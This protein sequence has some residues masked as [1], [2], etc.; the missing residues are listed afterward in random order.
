MS[1]PHYLASVHHDGSTRYVSNPYPSFGETV[2]LRVRAGLD[3]PVT[4]VLVRTAPDGEQ[5]FAELQRADTD[6]VCTWWET[7]LAASM[8]V[9]GYHFVL[10]TPDGLWHYNAAG[11]HAHTPT[12]YADFR[13]LADYAAPRWVRRS[14]FYQIFPD[15]FA[16][17]DPAN[18]VRGGEWTYR[19][20]PTVARGW[21]ERPNQ[22]NPSLEFYGGDL[23]GITQRLPY[24]E[25]LGVDA[26]Y[27]NPIFTAPSVHRYDVVDYDNVDPHLGGNDALVELRRATGERGM[28]L[29][30]DLVP[31]HC[32]VE[33]PW[34]RAAQADPRSPTAEFFTW[35]QHPHEYLSW[36]GVRTLPKLN[37]RSAELRERM[38][39]ASDSVFRRWLRPPFSIDAWRV[40]VANMLG[41]Q[42][43]TQLN[44]EVTRG[45]R[46]AVKEVN[47]E[48]YLI[49]E[50]FFDATAQLQGDMYD[51]NMHYRGFTVPLWEWLYERPLA[52]PTIG[53]ELQTGT[54]LPTSALAEGWT[55][56]AAPIP[57]VI[58]LQQFIL[59]DSHDTA[60]IRTL[61]GDNPRLHRL[62]AAVQLTYPGVPCIFYGDEVGLEGDNANTARRTMPWDEARWDHDLRDFYR[63]LIHLR[64]TSDALA[65]GGFQILHT[66]ADTI[67]YLRDSAQEQ[68]VVV[69]YRGADPRPGGPLPVAQGAIADGARFAEFLTGVEATVTNGHLPLPAMEQGAA[70]WRSG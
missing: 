44:A 24:L 18:N 59:V 68:I 12:D 28:R 37:Y 32:G 15:R 65:M 58:T 66:D 3:A 34:F 7:R 1:I 36:L 19:G 40:D 22:S 16:D 56:F 52:H 64:R 48:A 14:V 53:E 26:I 33:H 49:G 17:G 51:G 69:A 47:P 11:M 57:W 54:C 46:T 9:V 67:A 27:L 30:L 21:D 63:R 39:A 4:R 62:A 55:T 38:Y 70:I 23:Q 61:V 43:A 29:M 25:E 20:N 8:P 41:Q 5:H 13:L 42:G 10:L 35:K 60:R 6:R 45:I 31:N 2:T 50:N